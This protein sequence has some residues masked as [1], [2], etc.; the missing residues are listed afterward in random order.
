MV[1]V[2]RKY[3]EATYHLL[4]RDGIGGVSIRNVADELGCSSAALYRH[5]AD[6]D[7]LTAVASVR[8]LRPYIR[9]ARIMS[10]VDLNPLELNL[11][12][13]ECLAYYSFQNAD[14]FENLFFGDAAGELNAEAISEYFE[15]YPEDLEGLKDFMLQMVRNTNI[16]ERDLVLLDRASDMGMLSS[17]SA[18][19]LCKLDSYLFRGM[20]AS[21]RGRELGDDGF[22]EATK[23]FMKLLIRSYTTQLE[24]GYSILV[25]NPSI[26]LPGSKS[27]MD[28]RPAYRVQVS[29]VP[30]SGRPEKLRVTA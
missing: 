24:E 10:Q 5:F 21:L 28:A 20:L 12:L 23:E 7:R 22:R 2:K 19:Y 29:T 11:Q 27:E 15:Q 6:V 14:V 30:C 1:G 4:E 8:F 17:E 18:E 25:V 16:A 3:I 13:W 9:I 26:D